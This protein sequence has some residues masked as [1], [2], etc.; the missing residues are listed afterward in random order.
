MAKID[1]PIKKDQLL[2]DISEEHRDTINK[3]LELQDILINDPPN[4]KRF[5]KYSINYMLDYISILN[6]VQYKDYSDEYLIIS[7]NNLY[8]RVFKHRRY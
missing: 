3:M 7:I 1:K 4:D 2:D 8:N 5:N 6:D